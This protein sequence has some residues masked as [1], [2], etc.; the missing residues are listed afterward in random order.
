MSFIGSS[1]IQIGK[2]TYNPEVT[3]VSMG[4]SHC[5]RSPSPIQPLIYSSFQAGSNLKARKTPIINATVG[6]PIKLRKVL[7]PPV[8]KIALGKS[9]IDFKVIKMIGT[10][11]GVNAANA[12]GN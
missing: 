6:S 9:A 7:N 12:P 11:I 4:Y 10:I 8:P 2:L 5:T 1:C 3:I